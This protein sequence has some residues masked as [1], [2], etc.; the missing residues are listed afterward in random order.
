MGTAR[1]AH[2]GLRSSELRVGVTFDEDA[3]VKKL[4][5]FEPEGL[6]VL[7]PGEGAVEPGAIT[8]GS[9][10]TLIVLDGTWP[11]AKKMWKLNPWLHPL[12]RVGFVPSSPGNYR[13]RKEPADHC[14]STVEAVVEVLSR[15]EGDSQRFSPLIRAF[16][17]MVD[18]QIAFKKERQ[19]PSRHVEHRLTRRAFDPARPWKQRYADLV[20]VYGES[21]SFPR[22]ADQKHSLELIHWVAERPSTSERFE[23]IIAPRRPLADNTAHHLEID[24]CTLMKGE[25][26]EEALARWKSFVRPADVFCH[27]G[28]FSM[29]LLRTTEIDVQ[30]AWDLKLAWTQTWKKKTPMVR[31]VPAGSQWGKG[32]AGKRLAALRD[33]FDVMIP[34]I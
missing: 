22:H 14:L 24:Q 28:S 10:K 5:E 19:G 11:Q 13:I 23:A 8:P 16:E 29:D 17:K 3:R 25:S 33:V 30:T 27:W 7:F 31:T 2:L 18:H 15:L 12:L 20:L 32:R 9:L 1:L 26:W 6:A 21:N 34:K 4:I